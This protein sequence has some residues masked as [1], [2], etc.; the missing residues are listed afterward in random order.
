MSQDIAPL[1]REHAAFVWRALRHLGVPQQQ[2]EDLSQ[3]VLLIVCRNFEGFRRDSSVKTWI[4]GICRNIALD[5]RRRTRRSR[6]QPAEHLPELPVPAQQSATLLQREL[7]QCLHRA[8]QALPEHTR[9][10]FVLFEIECLPMAEVAA[11]LSCKESTAYSR[12][13]VARSKVRRALQRAE[14]LQPEQELAEVL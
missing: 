9:M 13:Y 4:F 8:L 10:V 2:L 14:L 7:Q 3:E 12:L 6:E 1:I 11:A 5:A